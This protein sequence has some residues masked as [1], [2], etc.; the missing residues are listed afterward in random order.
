VLQRGIYTEA[1]ERVPAFFLPG[2]AVQFEPLSLQCLL[3]ANN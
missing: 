2:A 3:P 1:F